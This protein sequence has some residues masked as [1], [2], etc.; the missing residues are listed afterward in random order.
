MPLPPS[1]V[2]PT[3][4]PPRAGDVARGPAPTG[5]RCRRRR[6]TCRRRGWRRSCRCRRRRPGRRRPWP[7]AM[8]SLPPSPRGVVVA[9][10]A[11]DAVARVA[12]AQ[13]VVALAAEEA[14]EGGQVAATGC[15]ADDRV[16]AG[17]AD[18][19]VVALDARDRVVASAAEDPVVAE[20]ADE[21]V[22]AAAAEDAVVARVAVDDV[23]SVRAAQPLVAGAAVDGRGERGRRHEGQRG[24]G[25]TAALQRLN[26][27]WWFAPAGS[28]VS[29][30][31]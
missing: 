3:W 12:A 14:V 20:A 27:M 30:P 4:S 13:R 24:G 25:A 2:S 7:P 1:S 23:G 26:C 17:A 9:G 16:V 29:P 11:V 28:V 19:D 6:P 31:V 21:L 22:V 18:E 8:R 15:V 10:A 5:R